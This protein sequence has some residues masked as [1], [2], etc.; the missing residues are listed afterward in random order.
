MRL[1]C[2]ECGSRA[3]SRTSRH[4]SETI[5]EGYFDCANPECGCRFK[6]ITEI[7]GVVVRGDTPNPAISLPILK[8]RIPAHQ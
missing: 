4:L 7:V 1:R 2:P 3:G 8:S 6:A 5:T